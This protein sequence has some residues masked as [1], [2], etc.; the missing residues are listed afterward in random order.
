VQRAP[1]LKARFTP[2]SALL[3]RRRS[4]LSRREHG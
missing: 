4:T 1:E 2:S 3:Q